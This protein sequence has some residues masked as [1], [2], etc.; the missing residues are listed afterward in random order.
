MLEVLTSNCSS[1]VPLRMAAWP[2]LTEDPGI[3]YH[4]LAAG[5]L[6]LS[7]HYHDR[8]NQSLTIEASHYY[9]MGLG[10]INERL[11]DERERHS[12]GI[13]LSISG[14]ALFALSASA[15]QRWC[16]E[17][18]FSSLQED[19]GGVDQWALH[20][21]AL[22]TV[23]DHRGGVRSIDSNIILRNWLYL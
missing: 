15:S 11:T 13:I 10:S 12:D 17:T 5:T 8:D 16:W 20:F 6:C 14:S 18:A 22:R 3:F 9:A 19:C 23:L 4:A 7:A 21:A 2:L 1:I